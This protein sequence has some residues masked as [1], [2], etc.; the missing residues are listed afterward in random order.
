MFKDVIGQE[1]IKERL[2]A[3]AQ[4]GRVNHAQL[5]AGSTGAGTLALALALPPVTEAMEAEA[6]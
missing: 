1:E 4:S 5:F 2:I 3:S 6:E